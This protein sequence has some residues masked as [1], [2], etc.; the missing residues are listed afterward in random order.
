M[1]SFWAK[2]P[3]EAKFA[4]LSLVVV[5]VAMVLL[6][7]PSPS[8]KMPSSPL[9]ETTP[10]TVPTPLLESPNARFPEVLPS[11]LDPSPQI[12]PSIEGLGQDP[13]GLN[14]SP[15]PTFPL[16]D[17]L[18]RNSPSK[19]LDLPL[20]ITPSPGKIPNEKGLKGSASTREP[21]PSAT[22]PV[23]PPDL[24]SPSPVPLPSS[25]DAVGEKKAPSTEAPDKKTN[26]NKSAIV[27]EVRSHFKGRWNAPPNLTESL[28]YSIVLNADGTIDQILPLSGNAT[29]Y[30]DHTNIP[31]PGSP[32]AL[33]VEGGSKTGIL[34]VFSPNG[35]VTASL[36]EVKLPGS[37]PKSPGENSS[38]SP[39]R[40]IRP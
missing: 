30:I 17:S 18:P 1:R 8:T 16:P 25:L 28:R 36:D 35:S 23:I 38:P 11:Y 21:S 9:A 13:L 37:S 32:L 7:E 20:S 5:G 14:P 34:L 10:Q 2:I 4:A 40:E 26:T 12:S 39:G 19:S 22:V 6:K 33:P 24:L 27:T 15:L 31:L 3:Q 29:Q